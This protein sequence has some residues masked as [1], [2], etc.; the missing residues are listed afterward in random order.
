M[1]TGE[2]KQQI[3]MR[4]L[5][6]VGLGIVV[7]LIVLVGLG[8]GWL[9]LSYPPPAYVLRIAR[10]RKETVYDYKWLAA[11]PMAA[12]PS[13]FYSEEKPA[14]AIVQ[15][16]FEQHPAIDD[17]DDYLEQSQTQAFI[18]IQNDAILYERYFDGASRDSLVTSF[19]GTKS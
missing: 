6:Q 4:I 8:L 16:L 19:S 14:E 9:F 17:L 3:D 11:R 18:V 1:T 13:P 5:G 10:H 15:G 2:A 12:S 7:T